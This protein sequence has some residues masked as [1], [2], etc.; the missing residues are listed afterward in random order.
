MSAWEEL[1]AGWRPNP[2]W[3]GVVDRANKAI[4]GDSPHDGWADL[5]MMLGDSGAP[6]LAYLVCA[7][8]AKSAPAGTNLNRLR[9]HF[10]LLLG[11]LGLRGA[12]QARAWLAEQLAPFDGDL[13]RAAREILALAISRVSG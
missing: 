4:S 11:Q 8:A 7:Y 10:E 5:V 13:A 3:A 1:K 9:T 2:A 12:D 6:P